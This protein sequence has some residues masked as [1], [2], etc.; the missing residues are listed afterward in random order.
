MFFSLLQTAANITYTEKVWKDEKFAVTQ[1][2]IRQINS[3]VFTLVKTLLSRYFCG[4]FVTVKF[5]NFLA[6]Q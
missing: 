4:R 6:V 5:R 1:R 2:K 3:L